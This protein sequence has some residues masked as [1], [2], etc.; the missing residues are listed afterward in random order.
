MSLINSL[1]GVFRMPDPRPVAEIEQEILD[2][3]DFHLEM[4][5]RDNVAQGM[6]ETAARANALHRFGDFNR[7][8]RACRQTLLGERIML[9]RVQTLLTAVLLVAV[10]W[11]SVQFY[12]WQ[13][14]QQAAAARMMQM[15]DRIANSAPPEQKDALRAVVAEVQPP[16]VVKTEPPSD[17]TDVDPSLAE[18]RVTFSKE[19]ADQSWSWGTASE[20]TYPETT[21]ESRY[22]PG[23]KTCV[24]P[25]K[26][27][28]GR[29][30][31]IWINSDKFHNFRDNEGQPAAPYLLRFATRP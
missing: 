5:T 12:G 18:I 7:V 8:Y 14:A 2:E 1:A 3:L 27:K 15:L 13:Q 9:Q 23:R 17:A 6:P 28:P 4:R 19:M 16:K 26:L 20:D 22:L 31:E 21:G 24:L 29:T 25:V 30:Y 11:L 10:V